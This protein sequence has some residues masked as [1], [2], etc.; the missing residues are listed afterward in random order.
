MSVLKTTRNYSWSSQ[1]TRL[2]SARIHNCP[3]RNHVFEKHLWGPISVSAETSLRKTFL[4]MTKLVPSQVSAGQ[5]GVTYYLLRETSLSPVQG[6]YTYPQSLFPMWPAQETRGRP[7][8]LCFWSGWWCKRQLWEECC[9]ISCFWPPP[10]QIEMS[11]CQPRQRSVLMQHLCWIEKC[12]FRRECSASE[13]VSSR[14]NGFHFK[15]PLFAC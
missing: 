10:G 8:N 3:R 5:R 2:G 11:L 14:P 4:V 9:R 1:P 13:I 7:K 6:R 12:K 15:F